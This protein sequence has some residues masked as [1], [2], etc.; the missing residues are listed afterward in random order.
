MWNVLESGV[1]AMECEKSTY[2]IDEINKSSSLLQLAVE[3]QE[4][5]MSMHKLHRDLIYE[6]SKLDEE[7]RFAIVLA[8][9][10]LED[11]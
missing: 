4:M 5:L 7:S 10:S 2:K 3:A 11:E 9:R 8:Y 6:V 1:A